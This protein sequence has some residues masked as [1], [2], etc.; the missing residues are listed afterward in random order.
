MTLFFTKSSFP[1]ATTLKK[2]PISLLFVAHC[3]TFEPKKH[4]KLLYRGSDTYRR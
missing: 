2:P 1:A 4:C 3:P